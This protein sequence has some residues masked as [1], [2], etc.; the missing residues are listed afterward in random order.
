M[1]TVAMR[2]RSS[3]SSRRAGVTIA[4]PDRTN[5][6]LGITAGALVVI[7]IGLMITTIVFASWQ[8]QL[9]RGI[10]DSRSRI[11]ALEGDYYHAIAK[12]DST[13]PYSVGLVAPSKVEY[14]TAARVPGLTFAGN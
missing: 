10:D 1:N 7:Y 13:D 4:M 8:T 6:I 14:V 12:L 2:T 11:Q 9:A 3:G 5:F